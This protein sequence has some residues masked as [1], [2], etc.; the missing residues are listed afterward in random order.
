MISM[1]VAEVWGCVEGTMVTFGYKEGDLWTTS[2]P[3]T[4]T[5]RYIIEI[6]AKDDHGNVAYGTAL[7]TILAGQVTC[8]RVCDDAYK[9]TMMSSPWEA[10]EE[11][12]AHR[13]AM[14]PSPWIMEE[15]MDVYSVIMEGCKV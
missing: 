11:I 4:V 10:E 6:W 5:G 12:A 9:V 8:F 13:V 1:T 3:S 14:T 15:E 2:F 7:I